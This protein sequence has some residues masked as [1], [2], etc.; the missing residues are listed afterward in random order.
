M[1][2]L[3]IG[4]LGVLALLAVLFLRVP[5]GVALVLVGMCGYAAIDG[6]GTALNPPER[7]L[8]IL[9]T[10]QAD[11]GRLPLSSIVCTAVIGRPVPAAEAVTKVY[12]DS[13]KSDS[14]RI[15]HQVFG[16]PMLDVQRIEPPLP[17]RGAQG[18]WN[19]AEAA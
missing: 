10:I 6:W 3:A 8:D 15:D 5:I 18:F 19:W 13:F 4:F 14:D 17:A 12:G 1:S 2:N 11:P 16:W 7:A 9:L